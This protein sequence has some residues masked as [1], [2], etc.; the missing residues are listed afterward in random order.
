MSG[1]SFTRVLTLSL[2][3]LSFATVYSCKFN[4]NLQGTGR[5]DIQGVWEE[6]DV[7]YQEE[8]LQYSKHNF[9]FS[10]D[11]V[12]V[13]INT[14][15]KVSTYP[16]S[17]FNNGRWTE[18]AKGVYETKN[19]TLVITATFTKPDFKQKISGCYRSGQYLPVFVIR[20]STSDSLFLEGLQDHLPLNLALKER[21]G[22][23]P[24]PLN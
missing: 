19:D 10:C 21:T 5:E 11:S 1:P 15:A 23:V 12:Y 24:K 17:C 3:A 20:K 13:T 2:L 7:A 18:Y 4:P 16:D 14:F 22:C 8:R 6:N 9:R